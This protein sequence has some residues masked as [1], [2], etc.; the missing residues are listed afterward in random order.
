[1]RR[2]VAGR[3]V[4][5]GTAQQDGQTYAE[6]ILR[7]E[8]CTLRPY[9][10]GDANW[11]PNLANDVEVAR[12]TSASFPYPYTQYDADAWVA[13]ASSERPTNSFVIEAHGRPAGGIGLRPQSGEGHGVAECGYWLGR[14]FWG[15]GLAT[16]ALCLLLPYAFA[17][18]RLRRLEAYV[19]ATNPVSA[20]VLE[21]CGFV[22]EGVL[23]E[24]VTDREGAIVDAWLYSRLQ[25]D[26]T[27]KSGTVLA[28]AVDAGPSGGNR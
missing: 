20:R 15:R 22:R 5:C 26:P 14:P 24:A 6:M 27:L 10:P 12:W 21:K 3:S 1:M 25:H 11:L 28:R 16:E 23:R 13:L 2:F 19:F 17:E 9:R 7:S 18:R 8:R 4:P